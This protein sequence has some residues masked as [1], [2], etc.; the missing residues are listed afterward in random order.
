MGLYD[1]V[2]VIEAPSDAAIMST[3]LPFESQQDSSRTITLK[4]F[5]VEETSK[6]IGSIE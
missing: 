5:T 4:A 6:I 1:S 3:L 2:S